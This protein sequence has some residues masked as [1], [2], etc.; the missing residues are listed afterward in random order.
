[1]AVPVRTTITDPVN[2]AD[3]IITN[4]RKYNSRLSRILHHN[5]QWLDVTERIEFQVAATVYQCLHDMAPAYLTELCMP[6]AA[7]TSCYGEL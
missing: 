1:M 2:A 5:L 7:S 3:S 4:T 6:V